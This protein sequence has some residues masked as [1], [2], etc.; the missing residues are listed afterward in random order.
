MFDFVRPCVTRMPRATLLIAAAAL[1]AGC[2]G[3]PKGMTGDACRNADWYEAGR[4][5]AL[6][7]EI[8][9]ALDRRVRACSKAGVGVDQAAYRQGRIAGLAEFCRPDN[10]FRHG[11]AG[12]EYHGTCMPGDEAFR[13]AWA[14][15]HRGFELRSTIAEAKR[16]LPK[17]A[18]DLDLAQRDMTVLENEVL[19]S[20]RSEGLSMNADVERLQRRI[21]KLRAERVEWQ[22]KLESATLQLQEYER[23]HGG[24]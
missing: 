20:S 7:G 18:H 22:R 1:A 10:G 3:G 11:A 4:Q 6:N 13:A 21:A 2:A 12:G 8:G 17:I 23:R 14:E 5:D 16:R 24:N 19:G 15:G 9:E